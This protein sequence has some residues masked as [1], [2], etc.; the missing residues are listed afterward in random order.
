MAIVWKPPGLLIHPSNEAPDAYTLMHLVRN[1]L[2]QH[3]F[4]VH[5]LDRQ[6]SGLVVFGLN[7]DAASQL[8]Q[9]FRDKRVKK[10]YLAL[11]RGFFTEE[12][13]SLD[14]PVRPK[15]EKKAYPA[16]THFNLLCKS[17]KPWPVGSYEK[18]RFSLV[19]AQPLSGR[20]HQIRKHLKHL[21]HPIIG[22]RMYGDGHYNKLIDAHFG[23]NRMMLTSVY[24]KLKSPFEDTTQEFYAI[25]DEHFM[26]LLEMFFTDVKTS[27]VQRM[28][29]DIMGLDND[30]RMRVTSC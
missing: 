20:R 14:R 10:G 22:D 15:R 4:P 23:W 25:C 27:N 19:L 6:T 8:N 9:Q 7:S 28:V 17:E 29:H 24:L 16:Q 1:T 13:I 26:E 3:V 21:K 5:R 30:V 18:A 12:L 2:Q 11:V